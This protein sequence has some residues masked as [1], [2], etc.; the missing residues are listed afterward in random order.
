M[1]EVR[2]REHDGDW[3]LPVLGVCLK[4]MT[5]QQATIDHHR[6]ATSSEEMAR[7]SY[8]PRGAREFDLHS[9]GNLLDMRPLPR[10][11]RFIP[12]HE[13]LDLTCAALVTGA[14]DRNM[15]LRSDAP[16]VGMRV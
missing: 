3:Q 11:L 10:E 13:H 6:L 2:V 4:P 15:A 7:A 16:R 12:A 9:A 1:I 8:F 5:L 14:D